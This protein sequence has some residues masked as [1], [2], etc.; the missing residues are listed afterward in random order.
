MD[1]RAKSQGAAETDERIVCSSCAD[2]EAGTGGPD[3]RLLENRKTIGFLS[4]TGPDPLKN[5]K[6]T[7][8]ACNFGP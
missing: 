4:N 3:P 8:P 6:A 1:Q 2:P 5:H 7:K